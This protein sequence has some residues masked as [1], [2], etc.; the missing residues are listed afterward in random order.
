M[1]N[2]KTHTFV[3]YFIHLNTLSVASI[4]GLTRRHKQKVKEQQFL[5]KQRVT[6]KG[7]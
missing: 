6:K 7:T 1:E 5:H 4:I 2:D 3:F